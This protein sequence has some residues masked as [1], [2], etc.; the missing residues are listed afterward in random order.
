MKHSEGGRAACRGA[1][2]LTSCPA[3]SR[4]GYPQRMDDMAEYERLGDLAV[5]FSVSKEAESAQGQVSRLH[6]ALRCDVPTLTWEQYSA[7]EP[8]PGCSRP[9]RR[10]G[11]WEDK[12]SMYY[13][14]QERAMYEEED[15]L[16]RQEHGDCHAMRHSTVGALTM[17]CGRCCPP[18]PMSPSQVTEVARTLFGPRRPEELTTWRLRLY[19]GRV[20]PPDRGVSVP[21][22]TS[23][24]R[25]CSGDRKPR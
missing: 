18:P 5:P 25:G 10:D 4:H 22:T 14:E 24:H 20:H 3:V 23:T 1:R 15:A 2:V 9:Y 12:G 16:F 21:V 11:S 6:D 19:C 17:H 8:C 13:T 7:G